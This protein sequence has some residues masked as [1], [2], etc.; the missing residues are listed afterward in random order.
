MDFVFDSKILSIKDSLDDDTKIIKSAT[1]VFMYTV[2]E[3]I[4]RQNPLYDDIIQLPTGE[5][6]ALVN[7]T[8]QQK[9][10]LLSITDSDSDYV[11]LIG[12]DTRERKTLF[13]TPK[14]G[15]MLRYKNDEILFID[16]NGEVFVVNNL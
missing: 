11:F 3:K 15:Q 14:N 2:S 6:I 8:S 13:K 9:R 10:S 16:T 5:I 4:S 7:K 1:G 12:Q